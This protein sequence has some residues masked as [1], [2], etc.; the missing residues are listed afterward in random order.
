[1]WMNLPLRTG[2][3]FLPK[4]LIFHGSTSEQPNITGLKETHACLFWPRTL[5]PVLRGLILRP[6][7]IPGGRQI[8]RV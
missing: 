4:I 2:N 3:S 7:K 8:E 6:P 5:R 1:M